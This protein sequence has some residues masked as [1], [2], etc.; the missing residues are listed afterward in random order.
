METP[1]DYQK[2]AD[3][4]LRLAKQANNGAHKAILEQMAEVWLRLAKESKR[5]RLQEWDQV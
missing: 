2:F 4:C 1:Q 3:E 5:K